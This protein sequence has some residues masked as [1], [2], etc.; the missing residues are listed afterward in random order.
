MIYDIVIIGNSAAAISAVNTIRKYNSSLSIALID[1]ENAKAYS[2][3]LTP[4]YISGKTDVMAYL[5]LMNIITIKN[6]VT[7]YFGSEA[8]FIDRNKHGVHLSNGKYYNIKCF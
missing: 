7:T 4:Y 3:V 5:W 6:K 8:T 1:R 2:R